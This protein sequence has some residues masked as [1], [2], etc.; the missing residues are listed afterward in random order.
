MLKTETSVF[1]ASALC[2]TYLRQ[3]NWINIADFKSYLRIFGIFAPKNWIK[4]A[5]FKSYLRIFADFKS[6]LRIF[7][8]FAP[9]IFWIN[10]ADF[11]SHLGR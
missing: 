7:G 3:N 11:K 10:I 6:Y 1:S 8:I 2:P 4:I 9:K 5:Y